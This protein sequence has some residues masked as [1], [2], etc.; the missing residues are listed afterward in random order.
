VTLLPSV[1]TKE[2][3]TVVIYI[4]LVIPHVLNTVNKLVLAALFAM[5]YK[6]VFGVVILNLV[7]MRMS[8]FARD[9]EV[10]KS[11]N[12]TDTVT[13]AWTKKDVTGVK[14]LNPLARLNLVLPEFL[15]LTTVCLTAMV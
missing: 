13:L 11:V 2:M 1:T 7:L 14:D 15:K 4:K 10:A 9:N 3:L 6:D 12:L 5:L 8:H